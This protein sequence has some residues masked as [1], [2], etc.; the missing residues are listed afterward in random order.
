MKCMADS[1]RID[2]MVIEVIIYN[3]LHLAMMAIMVLSYICTSPP[4][5]TGR[6]RP[7]FSGII[8]MTL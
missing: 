7:P 5:P 1:R 6:R 2:S 3:I 4:N 8:A